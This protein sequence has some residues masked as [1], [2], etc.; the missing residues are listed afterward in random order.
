[1]QAASTRKQQHSFR[2]DQ[3]ITS[4]DQGA[5]G[6]T[7]IQPK[8]IGSAISLFSLQQRKAKKKTA[9]KLITGEQFKWFIAEFEKI[10]ENP[11]IFDIAFRRFFH[12][13]TLTLTLTFLQFAWYHV[14]HETP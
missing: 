11:L 7:H 13:S 3:E 12:F 9:K 8:T 6:N 5:P 14:G 1:M 4:C 10:A 2:E